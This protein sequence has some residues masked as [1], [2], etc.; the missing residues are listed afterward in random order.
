MTIQR[1]GSGPDPASPLVCRRRLAAELRQFRG[2]KRLLEDTVARAMGWSPS[3]IIRYELARTLPQPR[4]V[5]QLL[6]YYQVTGPQR[7]RLLTL[8]AT[9]RQ[10]G[11]WETYTAD[12]TP[13]DRELIGLEHDATSILIWQQDTVPALLQTQAYARQIAG[14]DRHIEPVP[15]SVASRRADVTMRRQQIL[16]RAAPPQVTVVIDE[17][18]LYRPAGDADVMHEQLQRLASDRPGV[19]IHVLPLA[20][21][22][23]VITGSFVLL[24][25]DGLLPDIVAIDHLTAGCFAEGERETHLYWLAFEAL[26]A[27][28]LDPSASRAFLQR[29]ANASTRPAR[30]LTPNASRVSV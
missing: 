19:T 20:T 23:P 29:A 18:A 16:D 11:W 22:R 6:D 10:K 1:P 27:A 3:K 28:A 5:A 25:F 9:S 26:A 15:P 24:R 21:Q 13:T 8:A 17:P 7:D 14:S 30:G 2:Q 12:L 4:E